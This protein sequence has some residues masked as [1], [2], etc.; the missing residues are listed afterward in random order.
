MSNY[1]NELQY[2]RVSFDERDD[3]EKPDTNCTRVYKSSPETVTLQIRGHQPLVRTSTMNHNVKKRNLYATAAL[4]VGQCERLIDALQKELER[5]K[6]SIAEHER[7]Q[8]AM[9]ENHGFID[10]TEQHGPQA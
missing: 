3:V 7:H 9:T 4:N 2:Y 8:Q 6:N 10:W 1:I 5:V